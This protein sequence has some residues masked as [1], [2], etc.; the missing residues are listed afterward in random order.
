MP[1]KKEKKQSKN[2]KKIIIIILAI[3]IIA[4]IIGL[5]ILNNMS[6]ARGELKLTLSLRS[7]QQELEEGFTSEGY[8]L[9]NPN[10][11][12]DPYNNSPLTALVIFETAKKEKVKI[13]IEG[14]DDLTT[15][16]HQF[17]KEKV[18]YIPVYGLYAGK[19]NTVIIYL[20]CHI[21]ELRKGDKNE[22]NSNFRKRDSF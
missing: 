2:L 17:D 4:S 13:T 1:K 6:T 18:H 11:I 16:T 5:L 19:E 12:V 8:T 22:T 15:Y 10:V 20:Y 14:E 3:I 7:E 9:D 21:L